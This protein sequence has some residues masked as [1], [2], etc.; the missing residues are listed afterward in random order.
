MHK[1]NE[2][3]ANFLARC[4]R[5]GIFGKIDASTWPKLLLIYGGLDL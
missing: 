1:L 4:Q 2:W 3:T 5:M